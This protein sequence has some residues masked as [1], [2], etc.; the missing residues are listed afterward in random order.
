MYKRRLRSYG[1]DKRRR[2]IFLSI[3]TLFLNVYF[4]YPK[5]Y[6]FKIEENK[7]NIFDVLEKYGIKYDY[8]PI[9]KKLSIGEKNNRIEFIDGFNHYKVSSDII[10]ISEKAES[11]SD[12]FYIPIGVLKDISKTIFEKSN[13]TETGKTLKISIE[14]NKS[15]LSFTPVVGKHKGNTIETIIIDAGHGGKDPGAIGANDF[16]EKDAVLSIA[17]ELET[18]IKKS[19][20]NVNVVLTRRTDEF[21]TL[22]KRSEIANKS[23]NLDATNAKNTVFISIHANASFS[24]KVRGFEAY[25]LS[26]QESSEYARAVSILENSVVVNFEGKDASKYTNTSQ[27]TYNYMLIEQ[28]QKE[29]RFLAET[30]SKEMH[31]VEGVVKRDRPVQNALFYVLKGSVMPA[32]LLE[33]GFITNPK[34]AE[35][36][37]N[38][39]SQIAKAITLGIK[40]YIVEFENTK[41][42]TK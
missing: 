4:V 9:L 30:I 12:G 16:Q 34:D 38:K 27:T 41:G 22:Q 21:H 7:I 32:V 14:K 13:I 25:F 10:K 1:R 8:D 31:K 24:K 42:F 37:K 18:E 23:A 35:L 39:K 33:I 2:V 19:I 11:K 36:M 20:P 28:F 5:T 29:S 6:D 26:A 40:K 17:L 15:D 3:I